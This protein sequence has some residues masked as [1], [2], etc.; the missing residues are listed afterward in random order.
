MNINWRNTQ[1]SA[2]FFTLDARAAGALLVFLVHARLWTFILAV[3]VMLMFW[4]L[5]RRG[6]TFE[7]SLRTFRCWI[8]GRKRPAN[9]R[10]ARRRWIDY[11]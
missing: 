10:R 3:L 5:E 1:K 4:L 8:L 7:A 11:S 6:L 9:H 2:R